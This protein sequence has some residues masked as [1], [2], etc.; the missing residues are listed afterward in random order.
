MTELIVHHPDASRYELTVDG[1]VGAYADYELAGETIVFTHTVTLP[2]LRGRGLAAKI[3]RHALDDARAEDRTVVPQCWYVAQYIDQ[4][5]DYA[6]LLT[7]RDRT[8]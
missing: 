2:Q 4:H 3:V 5:P 7:K 1:E 8:S 6:D